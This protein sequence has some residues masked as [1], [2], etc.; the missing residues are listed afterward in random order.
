MDLPIAITAHALSAIVW[1]GGMFFAYFVVRPAAGTFLDA[2]NRLMLWSALF[3]LFFRWVWLAIFL[4]LLS[5]YWM[6]FAVYGG[7]KFVGIHVHAMHGIAWIMIFLFVYLN[8]GPVKQLHSSVSVKD[9]SN[10]GNSLAKIRQIVALNLSLG[11][12]TSVIAV[13]G[14]YLN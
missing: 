11:L 13:G 10:A 9:W 1:V 5:G 2:P 12:L 14:K 3:R 6:I 4:L 8:I 7:M